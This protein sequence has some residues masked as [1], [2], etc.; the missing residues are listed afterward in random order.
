MLSFDLRSLESVAARVDAELRS[1]DG[2]WEA[3]DARP[4]TAVAV[5]GRLS[6]AGAGKFYFSGHI[7]GT[8]GSSCRRCLEDMHVSVDEALHL[9]L[10]DGTADEA[11]EPDVYLIDARQHELDLRAAIREEWLLAVP[12]FAVCSESC[13]G[14]CPTCGGNRNTGA[15]ACKAATDPRWNALTSLRDG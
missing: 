4:I 5:T 11:D 8:A 6:A 12:Q 7:K 13:Q 10:V 3:G 15:C 14:L 9:L 2:V 1:D